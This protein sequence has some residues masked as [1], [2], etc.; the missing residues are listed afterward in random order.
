M[1]TIAWREFLRRSEEFHYVEF[2]GE[3]VVLHCHHFNLFLD[4]TV[5]DP[6]Y[7]PGRRILFQNAYEASWCLLSRV[8]DTLGIPTP[9]ARL[10]AFLDLFRFLG[11]GN[12]TLRERKGEEARFEGVTHYSTGWVAKYRGRARRDRGVDYFARG[13]LAAAWDVA[14]EHAPGHSHAEE[15]ATPVL[16]DARVEIRIFP[17]GT[18]W[19]PRPCVGLGAWKD[20]QHPTAP[21]GVPPPDGLD[22]E[23]FT[24]H[25]IAL[26][27]ALEGDA[28][29]GLM[30]GFRVY[31]TR[32]LARYYAGIS[33]DFYLAILD[34]RRDMAPV[35][36]QLLEESGHVCVF[37]TFGNL[38]LDP[39]IRRAAGGL[40]EPEHFVF[41]STAVARALGFGDWRVVSFSP[42]EEV[43][44][45][46]TQEY[47]GC[48][49]SRWP[50]G[51]EIPLFF[52]PGA[53]AAS[54]N[55]AYVGQVHR[56]VDLSQAF[57]DRL[58][59]GQMGPLFHA[60]QDQICHRGEPYTRVS[61]SRDPASSGT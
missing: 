54:M 18:P 20:L 40:P 51:K 37:N 11:Q 48:V 52:M 4:Q 23:G 45:A 16:G 13:F 33:A 56:G 1:E 61:A 57:Y 15:E 10:Q 59:L 50:R 55:L 6:P 24:R 3:P 39:E 8:Q 31:I 2:F 12:I 34:Q 7:I 9:E 26:A 14:H 42:G 30:E 41:A 47:E 49:F 32:H 38:L 21:E 46:T 17:A 27:D 5:E 35:A 53:V 25:L 44:V 60:R 43:S 36:A 58:M 19:N 22:L 28:Q 29:R